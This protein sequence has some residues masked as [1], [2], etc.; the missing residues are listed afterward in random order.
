MRVLGFGTY[1]TSRHPRI[2]IVLTGLRE[3]GIEVVEVNAP[4]DLD[5]AARVAMVAQAWR[6]YQ[7]PLR[8]VRCWSRLIRAARRQHGRFDAVIVGYLGQFD[9]LLA[10]ALFPRRLIVL[11][12]LVFG[13][14]TAADRGLGRPGGLRHRLLGW[15]DRAAVT[16]ADIVLVDTA[17]DR[18]L[19]TVRHRD[20]AVVVAVGADHD[21]LRAGGRRSDPPPGAPLR[22]VFF[23][24]FT[25]LQGVDTIARALAELTDRVDIAVTM[26]GAGQLLDRATELAAANPQ[27]EWRDWVPASELPAVVAGFDVCLGIFGTGPKAAR[28]VPNKVFQGAAAG[29]AIVTADTPPQRRALG[30][31]TALFVPAGN[32]TAL[33]GALRQLADDR[34]LSARIGAAAHAH[35]AAT[36][37]PA[38]VVEP[39]Y[40]RLIART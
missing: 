18:D 1:D 22:V 14:D 40:Q 2:G 20:K 28:V 38:T 37:S 13:A 31:G 3:R 21:W 36:F 24:L 6:A 8:L 25:P 17:E 7:L 30:D 29:C 32:P 9:V 35:A 26:I 39:L 10:R 5:T 33:A 11:D 19:I 12:Q 23:G 27:V 16:A 15:L 4:L 34:P